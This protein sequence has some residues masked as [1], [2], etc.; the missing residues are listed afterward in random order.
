[1]QVGDHFWYEIG[2]GDSEAPGKKDKV[3]IIAKSFGYTAQSGAGEFGG[4]YVGKTNKSDG[5]IENFNQ[6]WIQQNPSYYVLT[7]NCQ[8]FAIEFI[9]YLN[10]NVLIYQ[11]TKN[12]FS[13][14]G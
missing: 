9:R 8:K 11:K 3:A 10:D 12:L 13:T 4:E 6:Q 2:L 1:M 14:D 5:E 7:K